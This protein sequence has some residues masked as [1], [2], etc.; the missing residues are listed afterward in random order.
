[1]KPRQ[2]RFCLRLSRHQ[3]HR[4]YVKLQSVPSLSAKGYRIFHDTVFDAVKDEARSALLQ[5]INADREQDSSTDRDLVKSVIDIFIE[6]GQGETQGT[7][8]QVF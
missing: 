5:V 4:Y 8:L 7:G 6:L 1:M 2:A 3:R